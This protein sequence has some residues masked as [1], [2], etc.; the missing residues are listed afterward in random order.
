LNATHA[1]A[2]ADL[3]GD[4]RASTG[5]AAGR[6]LRAGFTL[7]ECLIVCSVVAILAG[8]ALPAW[9]GHQRRS[10][11]LDAVDA[12]TRLQIAQEAHRSTHGGYAADLAALAGVAVVS[13]QGFYRLG[14]H[15]VAADAYRATAVA[16]GIQAG[17]RDCPEL[18]LDMAQGFS[19]IGPDIRCWNR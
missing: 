13:R 15:P 11:R 5:Q 18:T 8:L 9:N 6:G 14:L 10:A 17:D 1:R 4:R 16:Q 3:C 2:M 7:V 19:R 12:L